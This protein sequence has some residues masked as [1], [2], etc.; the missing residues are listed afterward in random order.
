MPDWLSRVGD[1]TPLGAFRES[2]QDAWV[3]TAP[4]PVHLLALAGVALVA[5]VAATKLFH[6]E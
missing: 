6:W 4:D 5:G 1:L 3:G 2:V